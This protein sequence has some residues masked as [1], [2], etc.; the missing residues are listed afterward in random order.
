[1]ESVGHTFGFTLIRMFFAVRMYMPLTLPALA[2]GESKMD[3]SAWVT[4]IS[5]KCWATKHVFHPCKMP[6]PPSHFIIALA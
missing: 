6:T 5:V 2:R 4:S 1:M 3:K